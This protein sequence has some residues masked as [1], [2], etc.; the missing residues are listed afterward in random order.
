MTHPNDRI[1]NWIGPDGV[2]YDY[3]GSHPEPRYMNDEIETE[4]GRMT[5]REYLQTVKR[6]FG[7]ESAQPTD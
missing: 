6:K 2:D 1:L 7:N 4:Y 3:T 5:I